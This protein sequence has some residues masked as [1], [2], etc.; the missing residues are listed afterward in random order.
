M[1]SYAVIQTGGK[2][3]RVQPGDVI[4]VEKLDQ[5]VGARVDFPDVLLVDADGAVSVGTPTVDGARVTAEVADQ[6]RGPK[7]IVYKYKAKTHYRRKNGHRQSYTRLRIRHILTD[8]ADE[9]AEVVEEV[10]E[11]APAPAPRRRRRSTRAAAAAEASEAP[12]A[13]A[14]ASDEPVA[15]TEEAEAAPE[16]EAAEAEAVAD[17]GAEETP[18][19]ETAEDAAAEESSDGEEKKE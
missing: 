6:F 10:V 4:D 7:I 9:P 14:A 13:E 19:E 16:P 11:E 15:S 18:A 12:A 5:E 17:A 1:S 8:G 3:Y 2:Q